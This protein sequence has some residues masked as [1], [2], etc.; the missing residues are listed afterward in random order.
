M[1]QSGVAERIEVIVRSIH[2][3][4]DAIHVTEMLQK[5]IRTKSVGKNDSI[6]IE[7][8]HFHMGEIMS[9]CQLRQS[10]TSYGVRLGITKRT[11]KEKKRS[12]V[13]SFIFVHLVFSRKLP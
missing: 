4:G 9:R 11:Q 3:L 8:L 7:G 12:E 5:M 2:D 10:S 1:D 13:Y 6:E